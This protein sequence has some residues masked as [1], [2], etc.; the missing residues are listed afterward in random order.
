MPINVPDNLPA[1]EILTNENIFI[2]SESRA[3]HQDIRPLKILI[4]NLMPLKID[5]ETQLLRVLSNSPIQVDVTLMHP[6][7]HT[8]KNTD[9]KHLNAFY[10]TFEDIKGDKFDG[11]IIT[12]APIEHYDFEA[13]GYWDELKTIM[14]WSIR[15]VFSTLH[16][17]WGAQAGLYHHYGIPKYALEEKCFGI[18][19]HHLHIAHTPLFRGFDDFFYAPHSRHTT[20]HAADIEK[21]DALK[22]VATSEEAGVFAVMTENGR[23]IFV[24]G[25]SEYDPDTLKKE[26][27]RDVAAGKAIAV[28]ANYYPGDDPSKPPIVTWRST[29]NLFFGNWL[30]YY[31]YQETPFDRSNIG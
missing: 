2:M 11:M 9:E 18:F 20:V 17:C 22:I 6:S 13:V 10:K 21:H 4:L 15:N 1:V 14:D 27:D 5:T 28:P 23:Q 8:S 7:T 24:T 31:V 26:Y 25:H 29:G 3:M 16:I 19:K 30:N 12:G